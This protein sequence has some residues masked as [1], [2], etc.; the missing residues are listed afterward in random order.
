M[1]YSSGISF[2]GYTYGTGGAILSGGRY[3]T[4]HGNFGRAR[5]ATGFSLQLD[6]CLEVQARNQPQP[7]D[8]AVRRLEVARGAEADVYA[9]AERLRES[10]EAVAIA[11]PEK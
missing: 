3:D 9:T 4:V 11:W 6:R 5:P 8:V 7:V 10:G 1:D 2:A